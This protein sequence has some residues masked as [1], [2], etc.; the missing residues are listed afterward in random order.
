MTRAIQI[1]EDLEKPW[2][3]DRRCIVLIGGGTARKAQVY[4]DK[5]CKSIMFGLRDQNDY[6]NKEF[7]L[8]NE[9]YENFTFYDAFN[10]YSDG[11]WSDLNTKC[12]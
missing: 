7:V 10:D 3:G 6:D 1:A 12:P 11:S 8:K 2:G 4:P 5:L 9:D